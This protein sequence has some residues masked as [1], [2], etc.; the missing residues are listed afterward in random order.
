MCIP[1]CVV[2][3]CGNAVLPGPVARKA[4]GKGTSARLGDQDLTVTWLWPDEEAEDRQ[5]EAASSQAEAA[6]PAIKVRCGRVQCWVA[7]RVQED[8]PYG[9]SCTLVFPL[10]APASCRGVSTVP[11]GCDSG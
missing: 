5:P 4:L 10:Q 8:K 9:L 6:G 3:R 2:D 1:V 11:G 7:D